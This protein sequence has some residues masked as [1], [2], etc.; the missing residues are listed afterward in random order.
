LNIQSHSVA[1]AIGHYTGIPRNCLS[2]KL[3]ADICTVLTDDEIMTGEVSC[4]FT[5]TLCVGD[6]PGIA[7]QTALACL[8]GC[9]ATL[10]YSWQQLSPCPQS[11]FVCDCNKGTSV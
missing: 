9:M 1:H 10:L 6:Q 7:R 5:S 8:R 4:Q 11:S 2:F 3:G